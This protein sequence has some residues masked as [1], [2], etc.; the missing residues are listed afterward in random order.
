MSLSQQVKIQEFDKYI[1]QGGNQSLP[2]IEDLCRYGLLLCNLDDADTESFNDIVI[3]VIRK[4]RYAN[5]NG[6]Q[7]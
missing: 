6:E 1:M 2:N 7:L 4:L 5:S 3:D